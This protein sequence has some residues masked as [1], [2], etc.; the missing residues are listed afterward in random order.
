MANNPSHEGL[1]AIR[2]FNPALKIGLVISL[3]TGKCDVEEI[4]EADIVTCISHWKFMEGLTGLKNL[5]KSALQVC[6]NIVCVY[7]YIQWNLL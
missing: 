4:K 3:G 6:I 1:K 7:T 2:S 5:I